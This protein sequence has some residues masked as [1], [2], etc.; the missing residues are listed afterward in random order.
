MLIFIIQ[1]LSCT[2]IHSENL[3]LNPQKIKDQRKHESFSLLDTQG[4][5]NAKQ[6]RDQL[7]FSLI[8]NSPIHILIKQRVNLYVRVCVFV[9]VSMI[10]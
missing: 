5:I 4:Q 1:S 8:V 7:L 10:V 2:F 9:C 6:S 3:F